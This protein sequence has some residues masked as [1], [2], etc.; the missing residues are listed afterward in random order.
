MTLQAA[1]KSQYH[2]A[3]A[4]LGEAITRCP[5][6]LWDASTKGNPFWHVAYHALFYTDLYLEPGEATYVRWRLHREEY[7]FMGTVPGPERRPPRIDRPYA[8]DEILAYWRHCDDKVDAAVDRLDLSA[9]ECGFSWYRMSKLEHQ[10]VNV[11]H[12][13]HHT[14]QLIDRLRSATGSGVDW[15]GGRPVA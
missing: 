1:L 9:P 15:V 2:A 3:L 14:A 13:Q 10:L 8:K 12:I 4:M 6:A 7:H 5:D 11:R